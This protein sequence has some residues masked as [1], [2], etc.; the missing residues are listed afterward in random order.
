MNILGQEIGRDDMP[1]AQAFKS[2]PDRV[3]QSMQDT[4]SNAFANAN[5]QSNQNGLKS[6]EQRNN[7][8]Q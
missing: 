5:P 2:N 1:S 8:W 4:I 3:Y 7:Q 6:M